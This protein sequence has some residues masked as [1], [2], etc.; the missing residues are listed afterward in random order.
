MQADLQI[1]V[2]Q[3]RSELFLNSTLVQIRKRYSYLFLVFYVLIS[4]HSG[5]FIYLLFIY[6]F[7][8]LHISPQARLNFVGH[9]P[10]IFLSKL[11]MRLQI[12]S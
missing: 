6:L 10:Q 8:P 11:R 9:S 12:K 1:M 2:S 4:Y 5:L 7:I 3:K